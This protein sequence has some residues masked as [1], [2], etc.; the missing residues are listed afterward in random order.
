MQ[1][2]IKHWAENIILIIIILVI[3][4]LIIILI[5]K[6]IQKIYQFKLP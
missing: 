2:V 6:W 5:P 4:I 3:V 1:C